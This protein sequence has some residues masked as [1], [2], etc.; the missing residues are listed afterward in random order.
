MPRKDNQTVPSRK[1]GVRASSQPLVAS[2]VSTVSLKV[3]VWS[4]DWTVK[5]LVVVAYS[6]AYSRFDVSLATEKD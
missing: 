4:G 6:R 3:S 2:Y 5:D 1:K